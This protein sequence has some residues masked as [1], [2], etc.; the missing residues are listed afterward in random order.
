M[1][2]QKIS[3]PIYKH[4]INPSILSTRPFQRSVMRLQKKLDR[5]YD[6]VDYGNA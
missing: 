1:S 6:S 5:E 3:P 4:E 2:Q